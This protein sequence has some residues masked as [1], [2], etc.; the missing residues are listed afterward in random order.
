MFVGH[1]G[2]AFGAK[3]FAP[4]TN[5]AVAVLASELIDVVWPVLVLLGI[6]RVRIIPGLTPVTPLDFIHYPWTHSLL[7]VLVWGALFGCGYYAIRR[8]RKAAIVLC[9][10]V[11][12]HWFLDLLAHRPDL[13]LFPGSDSK[14]GLGL[15]SSRAATAVVELAIFFGGVAMY[16][17]STRAR[18]R[19]GRYGLAAY[20]LFLAAMYALS[21]Q[22]GAP[23][24]VR[25]MAM[26]SEIGTIILLVWAGWV[27]RHRD[28]ILG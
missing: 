18:D 8:D 26:S 14:Y 7:M 1:F 6:E 3:K 15:W 4:R 24:S 20:V 10:V 28:S 2:V 13:P 23:P 11:V 25:V 9:V 19:I 5:L 27:D 22:G 16:L 21:I 12:S 17:R